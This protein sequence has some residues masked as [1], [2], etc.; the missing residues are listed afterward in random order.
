MNLVEQTSRRTQYK[1]R[2]EIL[3]LWWEML[4]Y[5]QLFRATT[6]RGWMWFTCWH[7]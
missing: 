2:R 1:L 6:Q 4:L 7:V 3:I 5:F